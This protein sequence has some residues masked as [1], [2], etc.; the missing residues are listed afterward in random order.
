MRI[1]LRTLIVHMYFSNAM[2]G[3]EEL[4][5]HHVKQKHVGGYIVCICGVCAW[6]LYVVMFVVMHCVCL[7]FCFSDR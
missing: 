4:F 5:L 2:A 1:K 3:S 7:Q 6:C